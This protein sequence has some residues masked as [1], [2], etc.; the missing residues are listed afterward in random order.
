MAIESTTTT[1]VVRP[2]PAASLGLL[3]A[4]VPLGLYFILAAVHKFRDG[5][6]SFVDKI[7]PTA[8][9]YMPEQW[10]HTFLTS[11]PYV[12]ITVGTLLI[13]GLLTRVIGAVMSLMLI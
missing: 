5:V 12:E 2:S 3:L 4:R 13:V 6:G 11:L 10:A 7:M 8:T 9:K 1:T